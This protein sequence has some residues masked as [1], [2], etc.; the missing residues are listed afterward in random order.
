LGIGTLPDVI[1]STAAPAQ[2]G[3]VAQ[4]AG[5]I[6]D[7]VADPNDPNASYVV[8]NFR[9][10]GSGDASDVTITSLSAPAGWA[11]SS[12]LPLP[13]SLGTLGRGATAV[14]VTRVA[15]TGAPNSSQPFLVGTGTFTTT[16]GGGSQLFNING[17]VAALLITKSVDLATAHPGDR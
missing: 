17:A 14:V 1:F 12:P 5:G 7:I 16:T 11:I 2:P 8:L 6:A 4:I 15:R 3:G 9:N 10:N 13:L